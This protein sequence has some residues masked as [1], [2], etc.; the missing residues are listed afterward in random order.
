MLAGVK[1]FC[2]SISRIFSTENMIDR[3]FVCLEDVSNKMI[4]N[5]NMFFLLIVR[6]IVGNIESSSAV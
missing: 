1:G 3:D 2:E 6:R 5:I 4:P